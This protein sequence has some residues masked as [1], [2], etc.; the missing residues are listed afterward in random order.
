MGKSEADKLPFSRIDQVGVM[1]RDMDEAIK[2]YESL[3]I[4][5]FKPLNITAIDRVVYSKTAEDVHNLTRVA[6]LGAIQFELLQ[7]LSGESVQKEFLEKHGEGINHIAFFVDD[8]EAETAKLEAK[9]FEAISKGR[10]AEGGGF[11]YF[12]TDRVGGV[13]FELIQWPSR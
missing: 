13:M 10:F 7:P 1:V 2:Y 3:G 6:E 4:G 8:I 9:G 12:D 5:P 11:A